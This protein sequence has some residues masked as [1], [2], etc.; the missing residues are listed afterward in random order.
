MIKNYKIEIRF[1]NLILWHFCKEKQ[2]N[3]EGEKREK[4]KRKKSPGSLPSLLEC[5]TPG[6]LDRRWLGITGGLVT[7]PVILLALYSGVGLYLGVGPYSGWALYSGVGLYLGMGPYSGWALY[8]GVG[9]YLG[10]GGLYTQG[11]A[12]T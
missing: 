12:Y 10:M 4:N 5:Q 2:L 3:M 1:L 8:S 7:Y 9:L 6:A 11:W